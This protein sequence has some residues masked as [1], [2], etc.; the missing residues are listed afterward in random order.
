MEI[1]LLSIGLT[2]LFMMF[3]TFLALIAYQ[4]YLDQRKQHKYLLELES[5]KLD[6]E[7][8][9]AAKESELKLFNMKEVSK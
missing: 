7:M 6:L 4:M 1:I 2:V 9:V 3:F 8:D 5:R